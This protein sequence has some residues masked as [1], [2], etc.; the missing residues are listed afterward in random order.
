M[1]LAPRLITPAGLAL[2]RAE[3]EQLFGVE[4]PQLVDSSFLNLIFS[5]VKIKISIS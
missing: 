5:L 2:I 4:R 1:E 3:Y